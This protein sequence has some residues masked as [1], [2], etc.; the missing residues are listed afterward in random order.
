M[1]END[2][3]TQRAVDVLAEAS[4]AEH[5]FSGWL[6]S[7]LVMAKNRRGGWAELEHR[8]GSWEAS[9][10]LQLIDGTDVEGW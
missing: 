4:E 5:D 8:T 2:N 6:A 9:L 3:Y 1:A 7:V 10:V